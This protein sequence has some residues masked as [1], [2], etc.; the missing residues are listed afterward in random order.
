MDATVQNSDHQDIFNFGT[1]TDFVQYQLTNNKL[2]LIG[3]QWESSE[4]E[5]EIRELGALE[6]TPQP[7]GEIQ[8]LV[9][10]IQFSRSRTT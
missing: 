2:F 5:Q 8:V 1:T 10:G 4:Y 6:Q 7:N 3:N 9:I